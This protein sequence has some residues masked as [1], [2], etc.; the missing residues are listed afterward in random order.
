MV[1]VFAGFFV[2]EGCAIF[3]QDET[4]RRRAASFQDDCNWPMTADAASVNLFNIANRLFS[5]TD[6]NYKSL[7]KLSL[8][9]SILAGVAI[10]MSEQLAISYSY[11]AIASLYFF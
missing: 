8:A 10:N 3:L 9:L 2:G 7:C 1:I 4:R 11:D 5:S 6:K